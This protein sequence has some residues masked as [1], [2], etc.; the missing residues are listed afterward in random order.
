VSV[1]I[2]KA[3]R[4]DLDAIMSL[5]AASFGETWEPEDFAAVFEVLDIDSFLVADDDGQLV[6]TTADYPFTMTVPG[7]TVDVP[8]VTW[9][10]V[11]VT[12]RRRGIQRMLMERQLADFRAAGK[13]AA[14]LTA[15]ES[16]IYGR[17]GYGVATRVRKIELDRRRVSLRVPGDATK[18][19]RVTAEEARKRMPEIHERWCA[20]T[21]GAL[22]RSEAWW[23]LLTKDRPS[24]RMGMSELFYLL[25]DDGFVAYRVKDDW[26]DGPQHR[27]YVADYIIVTPEAHRDLWQV[28]LGLDLVG[29]IWGYRVPLDDPLDQLVTESRL[30]KTTHI[31]DGLW[32]RPLDV[33]ALLAARTYAVDVDVVIGVR[34]PM[35]GDGAYRLEGGPSGARC[36]ATD[37]APDVTFDVDALGAAYLGGVR[38]APSVA[39]GRI[40]GDPAVVPRLD[41]ALLTDRLPSYA[42]AF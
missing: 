14:V 10:A 23:D 33:P 31:G 30:V 35:F 13:P 42:L 28:L 34:D 36:A 11:E 38:L 8:G 3:G 17:Y 26:S 24:S 18:V 39:A 16:G 12:H 25:H 27:C 21:S 22:R 4:D 9:V 20:Q 1:S 5:D 32:L 7:A 41:R 40:D 2:R 6:G 19:R 15:S 29:S 37:R